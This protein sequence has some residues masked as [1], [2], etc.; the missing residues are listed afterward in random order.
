MTRQMKCSLS[1]AEI[2]HLRRLLSYVRC[3]VGQTPEEFVATLKSIAPAVGPEISAEG[4]QRLKKQYD[5]STAVP[6]YVRKAVEALQKTLVK[7]SGEIVD[8]DLRKVDRLTTTRTT[9]E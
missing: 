5:K 4:R 9:V 3:E 6:K 8:A 2:N 7:H 1:D